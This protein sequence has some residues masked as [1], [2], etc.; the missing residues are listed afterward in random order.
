MPGAKT[1]SGSA[2]VSCADPATPI[3]ELSLVLFDRKDGTIEYVRYVSQTTG[4]GVLSFRNVKPKR[5]HLYE[6]SFQVRFQGPSGSVFF[7]PAPCYDMVN[8][9]QCMFH[10]FFIGVTGHAYTTAPAAPTPFS[11]YREAPGPEKVCHWTATVRRVQLGAQ[12][13]V[14]QNCRGDGTINVYLDRQETLSVASDTYPPDCLVDPFGGPNGECVDDEAPPYG[15]SVTAVAPG[16]RTLT[17]E[18]DMTSSV[19]VDPLPPECELFDTVNGPAIHCR[20]TMVVQL[21]D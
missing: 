17:V 19:V 11:F 6:L 15:T 20:F 2:K 1:I 18:W 14:S 3:S 9:L 4:S 7:G 13:V 8:D 16:G 5:G 10:Q 21:V 12:I